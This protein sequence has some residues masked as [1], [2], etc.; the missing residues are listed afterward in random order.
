[1]AEAFLN[2]LAGERF[3]AESAGLEPGKLNPVVIEAMKEIGID[4]S[5][6]KTQSVF[7]LYRQGKIY[8]YVIA[9]CSREAEAK[10][11]VFPG[12]ARRLHWPFDDPASF[13]GSF[14]EKLKITRIVRDH[15]KAKVEEFIRSFKE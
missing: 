6:N 15:I 14:E 8:D 3:A 12:V 2:K 5:G 9:V 13:E 7:D 4:I 10:C 11:P 1:M